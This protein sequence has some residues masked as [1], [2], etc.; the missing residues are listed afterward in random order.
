[1]FAALLAQYSIEDFFKRES[2]KLLFEA[3]SKRKQGLSFEEK[4]QVEQALEKIVIKEV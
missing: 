4:Q 3:L 2:E 1:M